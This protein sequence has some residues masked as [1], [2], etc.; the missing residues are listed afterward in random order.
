MRLSKKMTK[1][2]LFTLVK[3]LSFVYIY[4]KHIDSMNKT[5]GIMVGMLGGVVG[6][7]EAPQAG[8]VY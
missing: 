1:M 6:A 7:T 4:Q 3:M 8:P 2:R 5:I